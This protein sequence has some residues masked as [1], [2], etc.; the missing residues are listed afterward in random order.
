MQSHDQS[1]GNCPTASH[2]ATKKGRINAPIL[3]KPARRAKSDRLLESGQI[4]L[5]GA[6][7]GN[8]N[9]ASL[10]RAP[11]PTKAQELQI[12]GLPRFRWRCRA[13]ALFTLVQCGHALHHHH[14]GKMMGST[15]C[16]RRNPPGCRVGS[17][18]PNQWRP[19]RVRFASDR[20]LI[21]PPQRGA[22]Q[23]QTPGFY[24][25]RSVE[26]GARDEHP[27]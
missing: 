2:P 24:L 8:R 26:Y 14:Q 20:S 6:C 3:P 23:L 11:G 4:S 18:A 1:C 25:T 5:H 9:S 13:I 7:A 22:S 15:L 27:G 21:G 19:W 17:V 16:S 10:A 12:F